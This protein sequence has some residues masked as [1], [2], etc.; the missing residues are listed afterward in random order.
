MTSPFTRNSTREKDTLAEPQGGAIATGKYGSLI[1]RVPHAEN[2]DFSRAASLVFL[3]AAAE[4]DNYI[5]T[6]HITAFWRALL[7]DKRLEQKLRQNLG[8]DLMGK[9]ASWLELI[10]GA[11]LENNRAFLHLSRMQG[12]LQ[13]AFAFSVL[14][15]NGYVLLKQ[16]TAIL[17][18]FFAGWAPSGVLERADGSHELAHR[19]VSFSSFL[20]HLAA[21]NMG[22][23]EISLKEVAQTPY[24]TARMRGEG[25]ILAQ[26][27]SQMPG[28]RYSR[29]EKPAEKLMNLIEAVDV[30]AN[31][32]AMHALANACYARALQM[33]REHGNP[34]TEAQLR[35]AALE[36]VGLSLELGAQPLTKTQKSMNQ[37]AG[38]ILSRLA[39]VMKSEQLN[40]LGLM[41]AQWKTGSARNRVCAVQSWLSLG[42]AS[43]LL[44]WF[45]AWLKGQEEDED[46]EKKWRKYGATAL[47]GDL[48][49]IPLAGEGVNYL[50]SL[51]TGQRVF[52]DN[53][54]RTLIDVG[55]I[56]RSVKKEYEHLAQKKEMD[57]DAHFNN[58]TALVRAAGVGGAF[59]RSPSA[60]L[61][62]YGA[63]SLSAASGAN[64]TRTS[65]DLLAA[66]FAP[67]KKQ[68]GK[69]KK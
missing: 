45:I 9:L 13:R 55:A 39:F 10:D 37:A 16:S 49:S 5:H 8:E 24:F 14:A 2:L 25:A 15:G 28:Q 30:K 58:L 51:F 69:K 18:G 64:L 66:L 35:A 29:L 31:L 61:S 62:G 40:K 56:T 54:A 17:H 7:L 43:S 1:E 59:S 65:K 53:Y 57:W 33:N 48:T 42:V 11:S 50:A 21:S 41:A 34:F 23:G 26:I 60:V 4:Q 67:S 22:L 44:A 6:S 38:G 52:A 46:E 3:A 27:A 19:H 12:M 47:L 68:K 63:L 36:Q 20:F 32:H